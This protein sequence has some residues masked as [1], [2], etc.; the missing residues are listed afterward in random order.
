MFLTSGSFQGLIGPSLIGPDRRSGSTKSETWNATYV[1]V[2]SWAVTMFSS[3]GFQ[4]WSEL[5]ALA[6]WRQVSS[7][8]ARL[9]QSDR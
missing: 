5:P 4:L 6:R 1:E 2:L 8:N 3:G 7:R 9:P